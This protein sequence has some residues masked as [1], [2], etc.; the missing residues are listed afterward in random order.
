M[1]FFHVIITLTSNQCSHTVDFRM[2][3]L[4]DNARTAVCYQMKK[5][6]GS[7]KEVLS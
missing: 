1:G 3:V 4:N 7:D 5:S 2:S 6:S